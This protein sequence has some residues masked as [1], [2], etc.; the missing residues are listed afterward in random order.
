[1]YTNFQHAH[2]S[3]AFEEVVVTIPFPKVRTFGIVRPAHHHSNR[4]ATP[5]T[6]G[7]TPFHPNHTIPQAARTANL[8][9]NAGS[10]LYDEA[11]KVST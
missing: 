11:S 9:T 2:G 4:R 5:L 8:Q 1:M 7:L 6:P 10:C 3:L